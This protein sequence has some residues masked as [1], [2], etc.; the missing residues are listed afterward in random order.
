MPKV[1]E[2]KFAYTE[3]GLKQAAQESMETGIPISNGAQ[4]SVQTY[5]GGG[6]TGYNIPMYKEGGKTGMKDEDMILDIKNKEKVKAYE[7]RFKT[8]EQKLKESGLKR[9]AKPTK[10]QKRKRKKK[11]QEEEFQKMSDKELKELM[12][13]QQKDY[14]DGGKVS[15]I[16]EAKYYEM[17]DN[18]QSRKEKRKT[19]KAI[20]KA[21]KVNVKLEDARNKDIQEH[22]GTE[23]KP[24]K[25]RR[26]IKKKKRKQRKELMQA[27]K[28]GNVKVTKGGAL[29][30]SSSKKN[31]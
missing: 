27:H 9:M 18:K 4:R 5:A 2:K 8:D 6:K 3:Q 19:K 25:T 29:L 1:G 11:K 16:R 13:S 14:E 22:Y 24:W 12:D 31:K 7:D 17:Q 23:G 15:S 28:E 20:K 10:T 21:T 26:A 30:W